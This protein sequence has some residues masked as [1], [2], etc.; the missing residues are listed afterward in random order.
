VGTA[1]FIHQTKDGKI[2]LL[3]NTTDAKLSRRPVA[4]RS[5]GHDNRAD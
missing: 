4:A 1:I 3:G 5:H 2:Q